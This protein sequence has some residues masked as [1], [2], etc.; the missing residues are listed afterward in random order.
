[1]IS[2]HLCQK[3]GCYSDSTCQILFM[4]VFSLPPTPTP[5]PVKFAFKLQCC[6]GS[7]FPQSQQFIAAE[8][9]RPTD[10]GGRGNLNP[11][12]PVLPSSSPGDL[13][14]LLP[15][16]IKKKKRIIRYQLAVL[17]YSMKLHWGEFCLEYP[18]LATW[19]GS[20]NGTKRK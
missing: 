9:A 1:M 8:M 3:G 19:A 16:S 7:S 2:D 4:D 17:E 13:S 12:P 11:P 10:K 14:Q 5:A 18:Q 6:S 20:K 15:T